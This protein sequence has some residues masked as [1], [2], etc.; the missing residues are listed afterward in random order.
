MNHAPFVPVVLGQA[1]GDHLDYVGN[2]TLIVVTGNT[3]QD[4][5]NFNFFDAFCGIHSQGRIIVHRS[6]LYTFRKI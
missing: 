2:G 3:H 4:I 1:M 5:R 6:L